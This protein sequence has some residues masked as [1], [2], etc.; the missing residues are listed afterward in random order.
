MDDLTQKFTWQRL[1]GFFL[2]FDT[3]LFRVTSSS[4]PAGSS[5]SPVWIQWITCTDP[6]VFGLEFY[7]VTYV[8]NII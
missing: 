6:Q 5:G 2:T 7:S 8:F 4:N 3:Q 1:S